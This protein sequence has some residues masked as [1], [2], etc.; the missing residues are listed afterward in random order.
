VQELLKLDAEDTQYE[1]ESGSGNEKVAPNG[2]EQR[3]SPSGSDNCS[4]SDSTVSP[5]E[6]VKHNVATVRNS[7]HLLLFMTSYC[8][9]IPVLTI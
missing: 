9:I 4:C 3:S 7:Y 8:L 5:P 6:L 2:S 1:A